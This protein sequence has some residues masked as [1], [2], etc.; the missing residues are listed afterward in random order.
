VGQG[1]VHAGRYNGD[2]QLS[3]PSSDTLP[4][5]SGNVHVLR[6]GPHWPVSV[7]GDELLQV[8][9]QYCSLRVTCPH[10]LIVSADHPETAPSFELQLIVL[11]ALTDHWG[12]GGE[13]RDNIHSIIT[14]KL[15]AR[16]FFLSH[17]KEESK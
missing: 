7:P 6:K 16:L 2:F 12:G 13:G 8:G 14:D 11:K 5:C 10:V 15:E 4:S 17:F 1:A 3:T 9:H